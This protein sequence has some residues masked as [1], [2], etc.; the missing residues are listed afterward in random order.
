MKTN[1]YKLEKFFVRDSEKSLEVLKNV[2]KKIHNSKEID[3]AL[4]ELYIITVHG[5]KTILANIKETELSNMAL[6]LEKAGLE[7]NLVT[8]INET[9]ELIGLLENL[10][11]KFKQ[12]IETESKNTQD[13]VISKEDS[14]Y[15]KDKL[16]EFKTACDAI[17]KNNA[18]K[19]LEELKQK[20]WPYEI[21][22]VLEEISS[23]LL[24]SAFRKASAI[25]VNAACELTKQDAASS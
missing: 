14:A 21:D 9:P 18:K 15:L 10:I 13:I 16:M 4:M 25:A 1:L 7:Q 5:I 20:K 6:N 11:T 12:T 24:H 8:V 3:N 17:N 23:L 2:Y 19:A 22:N